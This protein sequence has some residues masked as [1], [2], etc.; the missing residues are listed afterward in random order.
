MLFWDNKLTSEFDFGNTVSDGNA[1]Q[2]T[3]QMKYLE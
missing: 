3:W 1:S 2:N